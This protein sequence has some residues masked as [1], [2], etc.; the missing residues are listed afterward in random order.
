MD[1]GDVWESRPTNPVILSEAKNLAPRVFSCL[2]NVLKALYARD[3]ILRFAQ[4]DKG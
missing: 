3:E 2:M 4:N 1:G